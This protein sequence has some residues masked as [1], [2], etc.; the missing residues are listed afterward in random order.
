MKKLIIF[1]TGD[2][3]AIAHFY[4]L[5]DS[6][7]QIVA[8]TVDQA[9]IDESTFCDLPVIPFEELVNYF[10]PSEYDM[11]VALSYSKMNQVRAQ[12]CL[13]A[14]AK[15]FSLTS[16]VSTKASVFPDFNHGENCFILENNVIQPFV[17]IGN[18]V[19][20]W[21]GNHIGH[22]SVIKDNNFI[23]SH[24]VVSGGVV[25]E[26]NCFIGV[27]ATI[28]DHV[29]ITEHTLIGAATYISASTEAYGIYVGN[30]SVKM[31]L[32]SDQLKKI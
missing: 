23:S 28:R 5:H 15:G 26:E 10:K 1:G 19:T 13:E 22:H 32:R 16:Y 24:V 17:T 25:I 6:S 21:S 2:I 18:N 11:F 30:P 3:A 9:Y 27:N 31:K 8:F 14:K 20:L 29:T 7:Y 4:F 12:K